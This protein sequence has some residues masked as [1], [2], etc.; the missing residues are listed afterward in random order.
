MGMCAVRWVV[1][2]AVMSGVS[3]GA[4][5]F[6]W[7]ENA[8]WLNWSPEAAEPGV[9]EP[10]VRVL[11][12]IAT[13]FA[14]GPVTGYVWGENVGWVNLQ[15]R[16]GGGPAVPPVGVQ[17]DASGVLSGFAWGEN[18]GWVNFGPFAGHAGFA[19]PARIEADGSLAGFAWAENL[20]WVNLAPMG[21]GVEPAC[22]ADLS[23]D[24][25]SNNTDVNRFVTLFLG[26]CAAA[27][28]TGDGVL[29]NGDINRFVQAFLAGC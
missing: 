9:C 7:S 12:P 18:V 10:M 29:N 8:G 21:M 13:D 16:P 25:V 14:G 1:P 19:E 23:G 11:V 15:P 4:P 3:H 26:G 20:G 17:A 6:A 5:D 24:G 2:V 28:L 22:V 27:D